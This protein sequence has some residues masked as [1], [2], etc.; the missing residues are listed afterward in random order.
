MGLQGGRRGRNTCAGCT[1]D[2]DQAIRGEEANWEDWL[3]TLCRDESLA[4]YA[5]RFRQPSDSDVEL[6]E[7]LP[8]LPVVTA[9]KLEVDLPPI[10]VTTEEPKLVKK[11]KHKKMVP[12]IVKIPKLATNE[13][14]M[15]EEIDL[16]PLPVVTAEEPKV[17]KKIK[18]K[19]MAKLEMLEE[20]APIVP[21]EFAHLEQ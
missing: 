5:R 2:S 9:G 11:V 6:E 15:P 20:V 10:P 14:E 3:K 13:P 18:Q 8:P 16:P 12:L 21:E 1:P 19:K 17:V 7:D 4:V